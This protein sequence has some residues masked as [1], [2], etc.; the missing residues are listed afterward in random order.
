M[1]EC[2]RSI[3]HFQGLVKD[4]RTYFTSSIRVIP[5]LN[6]VLEEISSRSL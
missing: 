4:V 5:Y 6:P 3:Y 2:R 1:C